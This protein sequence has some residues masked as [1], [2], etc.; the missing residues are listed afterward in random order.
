MEK[1]VFE[2]DERFLGEIVKLGYFLGLLFIYTRMNL[3]QYLV[4]RFCSIPGSCSVAEK[5]PSIGAICD[6]LE[7]TRTFTSKT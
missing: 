5:N 7:L 1:L 4:N 3:A 2:K 6:D